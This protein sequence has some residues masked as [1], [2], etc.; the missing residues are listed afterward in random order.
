ML[1][2][3]RPA[4][5]AA[6]GG[7]RIHRDFFRWLRDLLREA[8]LFHAGPPSEIA[9]DTN[10]KFGKWYLVDTTDGDVALVLPSPSLFPGGKIAV[11][12]KVSD[13]EISI[14]AEGGETIS[15]DTTATVTVQGNSL[16]FAADSSQWW[17][18]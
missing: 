15:G 10:L 14:T 5:Q 16:Q 17:I 6:E 9:A 12:K 3:L 13:N 4:Q 7:P 8:T 11:T 1:D 18:V 2:M